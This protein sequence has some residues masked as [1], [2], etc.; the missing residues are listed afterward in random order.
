M[1]GVI[2]LGKGSYHL[3]EEIGRGASAQVWLVSRLE[4]HKEEDKEMMDV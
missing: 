1:R 3:V 4:E 2:E